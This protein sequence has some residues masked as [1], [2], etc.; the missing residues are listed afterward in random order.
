MSTHTHTPLPRWPS[1]RVSGVDDAN[2]EDIAD[3]VVEATWEKSLC[4]CVCNRDREKLAF[5]RSNNTQLNIKKYSS[6]FLSRNWPGSKWHPALKVCKQLQD[7]HGEVMQNS[8]RWKPLAFL[9]SNILPEFHQFSSKLKKSKAKISIWF[10]FFLLLLFFFFFLPF[11]L[12]FPHAQLQKYMVYKNNLHTQQLDH[13]QRFS[14]S[15]LELH[16]S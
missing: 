13:Y 6:Y 7:K 11:F 8:Y 14:F 16:V 4:V 2:G 15:W 9:M 10:F 12:L 5:N 1:G 3:E